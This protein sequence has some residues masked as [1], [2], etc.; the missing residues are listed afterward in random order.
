[1]LSTE[2]DALCLE[3]RLKLSSINVTAIVIEW[4]IPQQ[5]TYGVFSG[6]IIRK[7]VHL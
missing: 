2:K 6:K 1:M 3:S 4:G 5:T 7:F